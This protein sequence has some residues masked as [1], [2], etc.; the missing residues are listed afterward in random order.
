MRRSQAT[1]QGVL[2]AENSFGQI[3]MLQV[4]KEVFV[5]DLTGQR[6]DATRTAVDSMARMA[7]RPKPIKPKSINS[8]TVLLLNG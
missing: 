6:L 5:D 3:L 1:R 2:V 4:E 8:V 7:T